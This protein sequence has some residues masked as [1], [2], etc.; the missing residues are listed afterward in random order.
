MMTA[1][2]GGLQRQLMDGIMHADI[3]PF[4][5]VSGQNPMLGWVSVV[6]LHLACVVMGLAGIAILVVRR[7]QRR[8]G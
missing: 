1:E 2:D 6:D 5:P 8:A 4:R 7:R 3:Q